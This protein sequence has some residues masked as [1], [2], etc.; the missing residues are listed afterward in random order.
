MESSENDM[1]GPQEDEGSS[2]E[3]SSSRKRSEVNFNVYMSD[4]SIKAYKTSADIDTSQK[5]QSSP[6]TLPATVRYRCSEPLARIKSMFSGL[7]RQG[8]D[9][10]RRCAQE[11]ARARVRGRGGARGRGRG[12][13]V[14]E[15]N[16]EQPYYRNV[17][18]QNEWLRG[19]MFDAMG[20]YLFC[21]ECIV[22]ALNISKQRLA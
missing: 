4:K 17:V 7:K 2:G 15:E 8:S 9:V 16:E 10:I 19:N 5:Q 3:A 14:R 22:G 1:N 20:N 21:Q 11:R 18:L 6:P 13:V 12:V